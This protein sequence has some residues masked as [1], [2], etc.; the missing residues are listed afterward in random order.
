MKT[1]LS[2]LPYMQLALL[3]KAIIVIYN[4]TTLGMCPFLKMG[5]HSQ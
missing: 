3:N 4:L 1:G 2:S 5:G